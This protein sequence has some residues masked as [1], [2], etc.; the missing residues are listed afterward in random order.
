MTLETGLLDS[1]RMALTVMKLF[2]KKRKPTII[3]YRSSKYFSKEV[4]MTDVQNGISRLTS[5]N[6]ELEFNIFI[7]AINEANQKHAPI[8]QRYLNANQV[9]FINKTKN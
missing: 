3:T 5:E 8:K 9:P 1:H 6:N 4:F 7:T 2:Y